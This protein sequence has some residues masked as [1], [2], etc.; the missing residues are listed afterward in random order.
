MQYFKH[1]SNMRNDLQIRRLINKYGLRGYGLYNIIVESIVEKLSSNDPIPDLKESCEDLA[2]FY[3]ENTTEINEITCF[4]V[5]QGLFD[6]DEI[7]HRVLCK[8][9]FKYLEHSQTRSDAIRALIKLS[10]CALIPEKAED[11]PRQ[12]ETVSDKSERLDKTKTRQDLYIGEICK[13]FDY[14]LSVSLTKHKRETV[15]KE[16]KKK[17]LRE[18]KSVGFELMKKMISDYA[19]ILF[20]NKYYYSYNFSFWD[21]IGHGYKKFLPECNPYENFLD[22][23]KVKKQDNQEPAPI[24]KVW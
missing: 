6:I 9:I 21:F 8:K 11:C 23:S 22:K 24:P 13:L 2:S 14:W 15:E 10:N 3:N 20:D 1:M 16:I 12:D 4:M 19:A 18:V 7:T 5:N 17:H